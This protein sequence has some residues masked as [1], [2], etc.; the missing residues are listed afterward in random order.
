MF[1][2]NETTFDMRTRQGDSFNFDTN[3]V[4]DDSSWNYYYSVYNIAT[5]E[6]LFQ[7]LATIINNRAYYNV[8]PAESNLMTVPE[9]KKFA[10]Y[11]YGFK[12]CK[13]GIEDTLTVGNKKISDINKITVY[14]LITEGVENG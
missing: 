12:R 13:D 2:I 5:Q 8:T 10:V 14:P 1:E 9:G 11:G 6:I 3:I 4:D 7:T